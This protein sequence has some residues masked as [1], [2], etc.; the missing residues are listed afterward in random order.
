MPRFRLPNRFRDPT[1]DG[2]KA[3]ADVVLLPD[4]G[5]AFLWPLFKKPSFPRYAV[6][7]RPRH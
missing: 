3:V 6:T 4:E 7:F 2:P 5:W 1:T